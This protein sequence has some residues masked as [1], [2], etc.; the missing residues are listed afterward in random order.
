MGF[1]FNNSLILSTSSKRLDANPIGARTPIAAFVIFVAK[2]SSL[3]SLEP[4]GLISFSFGLF[5]VTSE[6]EPLI[7]PSDCI[8]EDMFLE[9][10]K[11]Y[12]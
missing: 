2:S 12:K 3:V 9:L 5:T 10:L 8:N 4:T 6:S 11:K 1:Y 7:D